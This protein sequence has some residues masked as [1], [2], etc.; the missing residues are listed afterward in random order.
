MPI[1]LLLYAG[2]AIVIL[3]M[4]GAL[5]YKVRESGKDAVRVEW[6]AANA[7]AAADAEADRQRQD[8]LRQAQD[9]EATRRLADEKKRTA[10]VMASLEAHIR[11]AG[12][13]A[14]CPVPPSL[15]NDWNAA[16]AGP[17][18]AGTG[19][20]PPASGPSTPAR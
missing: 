18:G 5:G 7:K 14:Q 20:V 1:N 12:K 4:L 10:T 19:T 2:A 8:A 17:E 15:L 6:Q 3:G 9:K 16:N 11:V 13:S